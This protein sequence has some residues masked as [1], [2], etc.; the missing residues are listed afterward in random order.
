MTR[1]K[2]RGTPALRNI[3]ASP[4]ELLA[5]AK[6]VKID[7]ENGLKIERGPSC[8]DRIAALSAALKA[9]EAWLKAEDEF[10]AFIEKLNSSNWHPNVTDKIDDKLE[11]AREDF[12]KALADLEEK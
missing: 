7:R 10:G 8:A 1:H 4:I 6:H 2:D 11:K 3:Q 5:C 12:R 9:G